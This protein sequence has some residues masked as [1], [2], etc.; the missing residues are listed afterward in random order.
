MNDLF[1]L[2]LETRQE[3]NQIRTALD[4]LENEG[5]IERTGEMRWGECSG[6]WQS[7]YALSEL[8]RALSNAG[9]SLSA[10]QSTAS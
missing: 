2:E 10:Y 4:E 5:I 6:E 9:I 7:V 8:G 1:D 3:I